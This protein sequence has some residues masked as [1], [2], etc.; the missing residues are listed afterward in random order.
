MIHGSSSTTKWLQTFPSCTVTVYQTGTLTL[1]TLYSDNAGTAKPNPFVADSTSYWFFYADNGRYDVSISNTGTNPISFP[2]IL[3]NDSGG[4]SPGSGTVTNTLGALTLG[5]PV[6][7]N[8]GADITSGTKTG[9]TTNFATFTGLAHSG[10]C[11]QWDASGN[12]TALTSGCLAGAGGIVGPGLTVLNNVPQWNST[13]G[14][15]VANGLGV[16]TAVGSP[17]ADTNLATEKAIR[18]AITAASSGV[19]GPGTTVIGNLPQWG[20]T[21]G[22]SLGTGLLVSATAAAN[23]V[24]ESDSGGHIAST[25]LPSSISS[26][27]S[28]NAA[29]ATAPATTPTLCS[30]GS[31]ARGIDT[32]FNATGCTVDGGSGGGGITSLNGLSV[33]VQTFATGTV[34]TDFGIVSSGS[35]HTFNLPTA[36]ASNRGL[37]SSADWS[38]FNGKQAGL[39]VTA[40]ITLSSNTIGITL[41][42]TIGQ[43]GTGQTTQ[44]AA[45]NALSPLTTKGD[46]LAFIASNNAR[47]AVGVDGTCLTADSSQASGWRW[48]ACGS[49]SFPI[50]VAQGGTGLTSGTSGGVPYFSSTSAMASSGVLTATAVV[51]GGGAGA[52]PV[53]SSVTVDNS[54]NVFTPGGGSFGVGS[55][56]PGAVRHTPGLVSQLP[57]CNSGS[58]G[59]VQAVT[60]STTTTWGATIAGTSSGH[61]LAYCDGTN[62]TV[63]GK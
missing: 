9:T 14:T 62:W 38:T 16:V 46:L 45:F 21:L 10:G 50:T 27:T 13:N 23:T 32:S 48:G 1:S 19:T 52:A 24:V 26:N 43:G 6:I 29:T 41:P 60:D 51:L 57:A 40:P 37:L 53:P 28:G 47:F 54:G 39:S 8:G 22:T 36:S 33:A 2:D 30:A 25:W 44:L 11:A 4:G 49:V 59:T 55:G 56:L 42:I 34:G 18:T 5:L 58:E 20:N 35:V 17:G 63:M 3:A 61:V 7:G 12:L 31:Y 15:T